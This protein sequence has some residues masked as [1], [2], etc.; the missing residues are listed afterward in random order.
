[1]PASPQEKANLVEEAIASRL[2]LQEGKATKQAPG[3]PAA[4][5]RTGLEWGGNVPSHMHDK[6][7][8]CHF[9]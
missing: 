6:R 9:G 5:W 3:I 7:R 8:R 2:V 1:V 4:N